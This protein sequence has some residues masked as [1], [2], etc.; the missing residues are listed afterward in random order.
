MPIC[1]A[2]DLGSTEKTLFKTFIAGIVLGVVAGGAVLYFVP[3]VNQIREQSIISVTPN[4]GNIEI[5]H[6]NVPTDRIL[7]GAPAQ[8]SPLPAG[9]EWPMDD[10]LAGARTELFKIRNSKDAVVGVASRIAAS[11]QNGDLIEWVL[12]L[13]ARG[14][15]YLLMQTEIAEDGYRVGNLRSGTREYEGLIGRISEHWIAGT[16][17]DE[18]APVGKIEL[19][20]SFVSVDEEEL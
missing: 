2:V 15:A 5:F 17:D 3:P 16:S 9:L 11:N 10:M 12:H 4:G 1:W 13:P 8:E 19:R 18:D 6:A 20:T 7:I 14:S